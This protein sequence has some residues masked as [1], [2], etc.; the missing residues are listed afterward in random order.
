[1]ETDANRMP[2][3]PASLPIDVNAEEGERGDGEEE[4][5]DDESDVKPLRGKKT[6]FG[7]SAENSSA[8]MKTEIYRL[9]DELYV[10]LSSYQ[11][12]LI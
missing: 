1:M 11:L 5:D 2:G 8:F 7:F 12:V 10:H 6:E 3:K 9:L 4:G